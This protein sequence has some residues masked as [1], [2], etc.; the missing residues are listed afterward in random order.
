MVSSPRGSR[1]PRLKT[2]PRQDKQWRSRTRV[3]QETA[4]RLSTYRTP[5]DLNWQRNLARSFSLGDREGNGPIPRSLLALPCRNARP[6]SAPLGCVPTARDALSTVPD[7]P[8]CI[9]TS[10]EA[11]V[12]TRLARE[13]VGGTYAAAQVEDGVRDRWF[14]WHR[15]GDCP[16]ARR[17]RHQED[18]DQI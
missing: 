13:Q 9:A 10:V 12:R 18:R 14:S 8:G 17:E 11:F 2:R 16:Q 6:A 5:F 15:S 1:S 7:R 3:R 4:L